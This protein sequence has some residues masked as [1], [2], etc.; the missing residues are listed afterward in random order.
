MQQNIR[1][2]QSLASNL[3]AALSGFPV[4][5]NACRHTDHAWTHEKPGQYYKLLQNPKYMM[6][7]LLQTSSCNRVANPRAAT[8]VNEY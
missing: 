7:A 2:L 4:Q 8:A 3:A 1:A 5:I 6:Y